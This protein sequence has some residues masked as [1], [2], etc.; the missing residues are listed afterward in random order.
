M[1]NIVKQKL[2]NGEPCLGGFVGIYSPALIEIMG[3]AGFEFVVIDDEHGAF[4][5]SE[6]E[7]MI[8]TAENVNMIPIV[9]VSYDPSSIQKALDRGAKGIHVP[10]VNTKEDAEMVV[11]K[12]KFPPIGQRGTAYSIR[13]ARFG[14]DSGKAYL[15]AANED[16]LILA[17]IETM[18][19]A[20]NFEEIMS[21]P[22]IDVAFLGP[23]DLSVSMG[24]TVEGAKHPE[25]Q[26]VLTDLYEKG[27][28]MGVPVGTLSGNT[29]SSIHE[30]KRGA[31][32]VAVAATTVMSQTF[33]Q[34]VRMT[35]ENI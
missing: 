34:L 15:D 10:M 14:K 24:Y 17:H 31:T 18:E 25:V 2:I 29:E 6:L 13:A 33:S 11:K 12:A 20:E 30:F 32:Y 27:R 1:N 16:V 5:Y 21:V 3:Y 26:R 4:S 22:G 7:D 23:T 35:K 19:A 28:K 9:R 8:R